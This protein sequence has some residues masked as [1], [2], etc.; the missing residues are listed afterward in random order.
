MVSD[1][2]VARVLVF[3]FV[4]LVAFVSWV[5]VPT[6]CGPSY[7]AYAKLPLTALTAYRSEKGH[8]PPS[9]AAV[10]SYLEAVTHTDCRIIAEGPSEY[11]VEIPIEGSHVV[12]VEVTYRVKDGS[13]EMYDVRDCYR[14]HAS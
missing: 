10:E 9:F 14:K 1:S 6:I 5:L 13:M 4:M 8:D 7:N 12:I 2:R 11:R 3:L